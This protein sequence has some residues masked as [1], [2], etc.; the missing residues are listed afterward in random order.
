MEFEGNSIK[1][2]YSIDENNFRGLKKF[3]TCINAFNRRYI[4]VPVQ[5]RELSSHL[6]AF[7]QRTVQINLSRQFNNATVSKEQI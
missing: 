5:E 2:N 7:L 6:N 4:E 1:H 3:V